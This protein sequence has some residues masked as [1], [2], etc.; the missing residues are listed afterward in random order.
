MTKRLQVGIVGGG[1]AGLAAASLL[2]KAGLRV[3]L[4]E[5]KR[6]LGGRAGSFVDPASGELV[7][8]CQHVAMGCCTAFLN[9]C[10]KTEIDQHFRR[11]DRLHFFSPE[12]KRY[13]VQGATWLPA[14]M[15]LAPAMWRL[16]YLS[17]RE[18]MA[19][20]KSLRQ[21][22][23]TRVNDDDGRS[24]GQWLTQQGQSKKAIDRFWSIVLVSALGESLDRASLVAARKVF[25]D[26]FLGHRDGY[27]VFVPQ[28]PLGTIY[29]GVASW[30]ANHDVAIHFEHR[31]DR[32]ESNDRRI[33]QITFNNQQAEFDDY[34]LAVPWHAS[35]RLFDEQ[36]R[37]NL[38]LPADSIEGSPIT[39]VHFWF[40]RPITD[41]PHAVLVDRLTQWVFAV[42]GNYYQVVISASR[43]IAKRPKKQLVSEILAD[44]RAVFP[45]AS[46]ANLQ[47]QLIIT[48]PNAVFSYRPQLDIV[49][50]QQSTC[51][52]NLFLAGDWTSTDWPATMESAVRSGYLAAEAILRRHELELPAWPRE[53]PRSW[54]AQRLLG[55]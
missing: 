45:D 12:G 2:A 47:R 32:L 4:F 17:W 15:H 5:A 53:L 46:L 9:F 8:H 25:L 36:T 54:L 14:P 16:G 48:Q 22:V 3:E 11:D 27:H 41:L 52:E 28:A 39:S 30:L 19:I 37:Q 23:S 44:L 43:D 21:L 20:G 26:G 6:S 18:K 1:L 49:R 51:L 10:Q 13:D 35:A 42:E 34:I 50:P 7:D 38:C 31:I 29:D 33:T 24:I 40:D 55:I